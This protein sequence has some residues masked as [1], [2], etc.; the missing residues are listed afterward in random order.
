MSRAPQHPQRPQHSTCRVSVTPTRRGIKLCR[1]APPP[2]APLSA[3]HCCRPQPPRPKFDLSCGRTPPAPLS[4]PGAG[5]YSS[6]HPVQQTQPR[7]PRTSA[8]ASSAGELLRGRR[9]TA[10]LLTRMCR[11]TSPPRWMVSALRPVSPHA[12][13]PPPPGWVGVSATA[14]E[15]GADA[16]ARGAG[17]SE[18]QAAA[19]SLSQRLQATPTRGQESVPGNCQRLSCHRT[20]KPA[21]PRSRRSISFHPAPSQTMLC[22]RQ[23]CARCRQTTLSVSSTIFYPIP[24]DV[25]G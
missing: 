9:L 1:S 18:P 3:L 6:G 5:T 10:A 15:G 11:R 23:S 21:P 14:A 7:V 16:A 22:Q 8:D 12:H 20:F 19:R 17:L 2:L 25:Q 13:G 4:R 24:P